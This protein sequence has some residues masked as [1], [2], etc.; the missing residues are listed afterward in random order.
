MPL[1]ENT[2]KHLTEKKIKSFSCLILRNKPPSPWK[3]EKSSI[4]QRQQPVKTSNLEISMMPCNW[5]WIG[6]QHSRKYTILTLRRLRSSVWSLSWTSRVSQ[7]ALSQYQSIITW[8]SKMLWSRSLWVRCQVRKMPITRSRSVCLVTARKASR[9]IN[10][11]PNSVLISSLQ[12]SL[13][14]PPSSNDPK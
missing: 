7:L 3:K 11:S 14:S 8:C 2:K 6:P 5:K 12:R 10:L 9:K 13:P 1:K 4:I